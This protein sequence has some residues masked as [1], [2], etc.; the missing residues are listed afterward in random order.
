MWWYLLGALTGVGG[1]VICLL[2]R[3]KRRERRCGI[4]EIYEAMLRA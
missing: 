4:A 3:T 2:P 1:A